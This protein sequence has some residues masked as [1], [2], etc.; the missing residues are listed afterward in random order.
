M[1]MNVPQANSRAI[2]HIAIVGGGMT[3]WTVAAALV[4]GLRGLD[5]KIRVLDNHHYPAAD[6]PIETT[7]P[8]CVAFHDWLGISEPHLIEAT[9][10]SYILA[11]RFNGW[12]HAQQNY[13]MPFNDHG[14]MLNRIDFAQY[15]TGCYLRGSALD[16]DD[17]S[18][19]A[20]A[21]KAGKFCHPSQKGASIFST[22]SYGLV[23]NPSEY[24][25]YLRRFALS[26]GVEQ[27]AA[28]VIDISVDADGYIESLGLLTDNEKSTLAADLFIDC[29]GIPGLLIEGKLNVHWDSLTN[30][31]NDKHHPVSHQL[32]LV[33]G[34]DGAQELPVAR[35]LEI[36]AT[37]WLHKATSQT[38]S[39]RQYYYHQEYTSPAQIES[40]I[41]E[42]YPIAQVQEM[43][44]GRRKNF[45][46]KNCVAIGHSAAN[47]DVVSI[48]KLHLVQSA[49]LRLLSI[50]PA[51]VD[52]TFNSAEYNRLTHLELDHIEDFHALHYYLAG[53]KAG[54]Y[55]QAIARAKLSD[56]LTHKLEIF[57][58]RG[59]IPFYEGE[60]FSTG[61]WSSLLLG[62]G[63]WPQACTPLVD[64]QDQAWVAQQ[65]EKMKAVIVSAVAQMPSHAGYLRRQS[66]ARA[67]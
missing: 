57:R 63:Y 4:R 66:P 31:N 26:S 51:R 39:V 8:A 16:Y 5:I 44:T 20:M 3:G 18:L 37:G 48:G 13:F 33:Q 15:A 17:Y 6:A 53:I 43:R 58:R 50:F 49:V 32:N 34:V 10:A 45:W 1:N 28:D 21:A 65:L 30:A 52:T 62:N 55:W 9:G 36:T 41:D 59:I 38:K 35:E 12:S 54:E 11:T 61:V 22:L 27:S 46:N 29:T 42:D 56:R 2:K 24:T 25:A 40:V 7:T 14:F 60:T 23:L 64:H 47:P 19:S 67:Q